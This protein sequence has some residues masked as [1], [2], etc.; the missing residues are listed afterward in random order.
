M[1]WNC[2]FVW[3]NLSASRRTSQIFGERWYGKSLLGFCL[4]AAIY[5]YWYI[6]LLYI[7]II[8]PGQNGGKE[9]SPSILFYYPRPHSWRRWRSPVS[10]GDIGHHPSLFYNLL[11]IEI[12]IQIHH[13][14]YLTT[15][16]KLRMIECDSIGGEKVVANWRGRLVPSRQVQ[17]SQL[18]HRILQSQVKRS[19]MQGK[20]FFVHIGMWWWLSIT[21][22]HP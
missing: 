18:F 9:I 12:Q 7:S 8:C 19:H 22:Q 10:W 21:K 2:L 6:S 15:P 5:W 13:S 3:S 20:C 16:K 17:E 11:R 4:V 14:W 1:K